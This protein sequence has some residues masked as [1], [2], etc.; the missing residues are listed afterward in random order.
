[1][2]RPAVSI[3][4]PVHN[5]PALLEECVRSALAQDFHDFEIV[6]SDNHSTDGTWEVC[7]RLARENPG[8]VRI[9]RNPAD[10]GPVRN[11]KRCLDEA[12]GRFGKFVYSDDLVHPGFLSQ[13]LPWIERDDVA[14]VFTQ[15][16]L[17]DLPGTGEIG[18]KWRPATGTY[19]STE[20]QESLVLGTG[21]VP[22]SPGCGLFRTDDLRAN[23]LERLPTGR[24]FSSHGGGADAMLYLLTSRARPAVAYVAKPLCFFRRHPGS[25]TVQG[26][27]GNVRDSYFEAFLWFARDEG[28]DDW[29]ER[30]QARVWL[31]EM[32]R[33]RGWLSAESALSRFHTPVCGP[34][35]LWRRVPR[36]AGSLVSH[37]VRLRVARA[38]RAAQ[39]RAP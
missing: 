27:G 24:D 25:I 1:M 3:L 32:R 12:R 28:R 14:F 29:L 37:T 31:L 17:G 26:M 34:G 4:V 15:A 9:F 18:W 11:W 33:A 30:L 7:E 13:T 22:V 35:R 39:M 16:E 8:I 19:P 36:E 5:R 10:L 2:S 6:I 38:A 21:D 20:F 23:L